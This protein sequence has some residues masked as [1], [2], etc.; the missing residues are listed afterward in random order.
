MNFLTPVFLFIAARFVDIV[1]F[2]YTIVARLF[3]YPNNPGM[4]A[5]KPDSVNAFFESSTR[6]K[7]LT[8]IDL[9]FFPY[10]WYDALIGKSP[11]LSVPPKYYINEVIDGCHNFYI[12]L[13]SNNYFLPDWLSQWLQLTFNI[14]T[15]TTNL[16]YIQEGIFIFLLV[17]M[18]LIG[19]RINLF[20]FIAIN[21]FVRPWIYITSLVDWAY[22]IT[23]GI[24]P[25]I[26]GLDV[27]MI[28]FFSL[29]GK[30]TDIINSLIFTMP[31]LPSEGHKQQI[32]QS[33]ASP[34]DLLFLFAKAKKDDEKVVKTVLFFKDLPHLWH[35][36]PIPN[37]I[38]EF[39]FYQ[40]PEILKFM[41]DKYGK[42]EVNFYP[43]KIYKYLENHNMSIDN[44]VNLSHTAIENDIEKVI[45]IIKDNIPT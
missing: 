36:Y 17:Y 20:W 33:E 14:A 38:R 27:G 19:F 12:D 23:A 34:Q 21:P 45:S 31:F 10:K 11:P 7:Y 39:W 42:L 18:K 9:S 15:D 22:D 30:F 28:L 1:T 13:Y 4:P 41:V 44:F 3:G 32:S 8:P 29:I 16:E 2:F 6:P 25:G 26:F 37:N 40:K 35:I 24:V 43:D 5:V